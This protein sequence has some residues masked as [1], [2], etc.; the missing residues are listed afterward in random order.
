MSKTVIEFTPDEG[1]VSF[2]KRKRMPGTKTKMNKEVK[3]VNTAANQAGGYTAY[4]VR[5][6]L[7][8]AASQDGSIYIY[9]WR[10][11]HLAYP[12]MG[13]ENWQRIGNTFFL[14][15]LRIKGYITYTSRNILRP[16]HW[17]LKLYRFEGA[18]PYV[19]TNSSTAL[20]QVNQYASLF[21]N[22][23]MPVDW[24]SGSQCIAASRHN[25]WKAIKKYPKEYDYT[26]KTIASGVIPKSN[27]FVSTGTVT[28]GSQTTY[29]VGAQTETS[30]ND[31]GDFP[32]DV[33]V[34]L[35]DRIVYKDTNYSA[36]YFLVFEDDFGQYLKVTEGTSS[37]IPT[38]S[39]T[40]Q[41]DY[42][43]YS[44]EFWSRFYFTD[45]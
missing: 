33:I 18:S 31:S 16:I 17:R 15:A 6:C 23:E 36:N 42:K 35:H 30:N 10:L 5:P 20:D 43:V 2:K 40:N 39:I 7:S 13:I 28:Y 1:R 32:L 3:Q 25:F 29:S 44:L 37:T 12:G 14:R 34:K 19:W 4:T 9:P 8:T 26:C 41:L 21:T 24:T 27:S 38:W 22:W 45:D 11:S